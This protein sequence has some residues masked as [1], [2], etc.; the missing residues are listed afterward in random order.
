VTS[1]P[2]RELTWGQ[3]WSRRLAA[4]HLADPAPRERLV[5]VVRAMGGVHAQVMASAEVAV[6]LRVA[7]ATRSDLREE[8]WE[9]RTLVKTYGLRGT[10]HVFAAD[11][12]SLWL[13]ALRAARPP[14][15]DP[16][17]DGRTQ[18]VISAIAE[19][20]DGR[21]LTREELGE[22]VGRRAGQWALERTFPAFGGAWP[23]WWAMIGA[24]A[25]AGGL[26][27]GPNRGNRVTF[28]RPDQ[29]LAGRPQGEVDAGEALREVLR[30][31][32]A[33][34]GPAR[35]ADFARWLA[36][37]ERL[38]VELV[39]GLG[40]EL[41]EVDVEGWRAW[42]LAGAA[43]ETAEPAETAGQSVRLLPHFDGY[44]IACHPRERLVPPDVRARLDGS[45]A[46]AW[47]RR[48]LA[49]GAVGSLPTLLVGGVVAGVWER[50]REGR[51]LVVRV[52]PFGPL[53]A[54]QRRG[55]E[56]EASRVGEILEASATLE[57]GAVE[58]RPHL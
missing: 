33:A 12:L 21:R 17:P 48:G 24:A 56:R 15:G 40:G 52:E 26:C 32:L 3:V 25:L 43:A 2:V 51:R 49:V 22:E 20:L 7:G 45:A 57:L 4:H 14:A 34:H 28:V 1:G 29:W 55:L 6:G 13:A 58:V 30:R 50:R 53:S 9:R 42:Q 39:R 8:L 46:P 5:D 23:V 19:A 10:V 47:V 11:E 44:V 38:A 54:A 16:A 36:M 37:D 27:F 41:E 31:Y 35:A 18:A